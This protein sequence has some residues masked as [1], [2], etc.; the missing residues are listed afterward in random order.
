MP[1][2]LEI[3][4]VRSLAGASQHQRKVIK[5]LGLRHREHVITHE[6]TLTIKGMIAKVAHLVQVTK[7]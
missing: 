4:Q 5:A 1:G 7:R 6:D 2:K 3:K